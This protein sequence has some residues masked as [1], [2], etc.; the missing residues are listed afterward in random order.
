MYGN[1]Q[2][3]QAINFDSYLEEDDREDKERNPCPFELGM[4]VRADRQPYGKSQGQEDLRERVRKPRV[5]E[6]ECLER[7]R[8]R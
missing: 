8:K 3:C 1:L 2:S 7:D 5:S 4:E 6:K